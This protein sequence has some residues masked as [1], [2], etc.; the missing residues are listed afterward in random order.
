MLSNKKKKLDLDIEREIKKIAGKRVRFNELIKNY[1]T[2]CVGGPV[3]YLVK[4]NSVEELKIL[5]CLLN[6][7]NIDYRVIGAGSNL[8]VKDKGISGALLKLEGEF[9]RIQV[10]DE[11]LI[12]GAGVRIPVLIKKCVD[13]CLQGVEFLAG[14]PGT[15]GGALMMNAGIQK[16]EIGNLVEELEVFNEN[17]NISLLRKPDLVFGYRN[18]N[19]LKNN[20]IL[21][22]KLLLKKGNKN[23]ILSIIKSNLQRRAQTQPVNSHSAGCIFRNPLNKS[24]LTAGELIERAGLKGERKGKAQIST[25]HANFIVNLKGAQAKD[26]LFLIKKIKKKIDEIFGIRLQLEIEI[27]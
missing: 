2:F 26:I 21:K 9:N 8:L 17:G 12:V 10:V 11:K 13:C 25:K 27:W 18:N 20:I 6:K 4:V 23:D 3:D 7:N 24:Q 16:Q 5:I 1:T 14:I 19:I 15:V 22:A